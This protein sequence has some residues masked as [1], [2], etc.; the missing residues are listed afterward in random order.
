MQIINEITNYSIAS[1][2]WVLMFSVRVCSRKQHSFAC[3]S[4]NRQSYEKRDF[5]E[6]PILDTMIIYTPLCVA[7]LIYTPK[8]TLQIQSENEGSTP[9]GVQIIKWHQEWLY[10]EILPQKIRSNL[11][12]KKPT[13]YPQGLNTGLKM[14]LGRHHSIEVLW[15][16][17]LQFGES[18]GLISKLAL[19]FRNDNCRSS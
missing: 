5:E 18:L 10:F 14:S 11:L 6:Y 1:K 3:F 12:L 13:Y 15:V 4:E 16:F 7:L 19:P 2:V 17:V 8:F 9:H